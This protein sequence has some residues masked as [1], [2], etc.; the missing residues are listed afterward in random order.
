MRM[1]IKIIFI[2][3]LLSGCNQY[4][5]YDG[6]Y[7]EDPY[8]CYNHGGYS[9]FR[10]K[11]RPSS[12]AGQWIVTLARSAGECPGVPDAL[13][14]TIGL[15][16]NQQKITARVAGVIGALRGSLRNKKAHLSIYQSQPCVVTGS[17][18]L[19]FTSNSHAVVFGSANVDCGL[20]Y[21]CAA[22]YRGTAAKN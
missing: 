1:T 12:Y 2:T 21:Q 20:I 10:L 13:I 8:Y 16:Q 9:L 5:C 19:T 6:T 22:T 17:A 7:V 14:S 3:A 11:A 15:S 18:D 4:V